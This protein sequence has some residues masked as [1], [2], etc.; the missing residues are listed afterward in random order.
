MRRTLN[1]LWRPK[2]GGL[3]VE[4]L[5]KDSRRF[6]ADYAIDDKLEV[7]SLRAALVGLIIEKK[8]TYWWYPGNNQL[9]IF[10]KD[11]Q[12]TQLTAFILPFMW[13]YPDLQFE[14]GA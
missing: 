6:N 4:R 9:A 1:L 7:H 2:W 13:L 5:L 10:S 3:R 12:N 11:L 8:G 14:G